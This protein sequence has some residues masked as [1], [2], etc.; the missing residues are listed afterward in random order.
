MPWN[1]AK[2]EQRIGR[3]DRIGQTA[4]VV[5]VVNVWYPDTYEAR[6]YRVLF[7]RQHIWWIIVGPASGIISQ[8]LVEAF[9]EGLGGESLQR[10]IVETVEQVEQS[11]DEA[12]RLSRIFPEDIPLKPTFVE[13][14]VTHVLER[15]LNLACEALGMR[16]VR[17]RVGDEERLFVEPLERLPEGVRVFVEDGISLMP[18]R[19]NALVPGHPFVQWVASEVEL[20]ADMPRKVPFSVYGVGTEDGLLDVYVMEPGGRPVRVEDAGRVVELFRYVLA[21]AEREVG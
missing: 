7:E 12:I 21:L 4:D 2:V 17:R 8:R 10:R 11:K 15:F 3:V 16:L 9:A 5:K 1:P 13:V 14:E 6:M 20:F 18:G 19:P